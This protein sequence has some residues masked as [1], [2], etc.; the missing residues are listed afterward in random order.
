MKGLL[1]PSQWSGY[2]SV[3]AWS[4]GRCCLRCCGLVNLASCG[5]STYE[6]GFGCLTVSPCFTHS[7]MHLP[8]ACLLFLFCLVWGWLLVF[9]F[10]SA[11]RIFCPFFSNALDD[12]QCF[13]ARSAMRK[14]FPPCRARHDSSDGRANS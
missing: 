11:F 2:D 8:S 14:N 7:F 9:C 3:D 5:S 4:Q 10:A 12:R 6:S 13:I 1:C